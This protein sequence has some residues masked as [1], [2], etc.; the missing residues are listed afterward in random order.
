LLEIFG[1]NEKASVTAAERNA[2]ARVVAE[3]KRQMQR[4]KT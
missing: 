3:I 2:L 4:T 1:K